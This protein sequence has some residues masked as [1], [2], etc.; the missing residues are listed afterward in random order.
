MRV[1]EAGALPSGRVVLS[2]PASLLRPPPTPWWPPATSRPSPVI[3]RHCFPSPAGSGP[4]RASPVPTTPLRP[5]HAPYAGG[6][7]GHP[8]QVPWCRPWPSPQEYRL[9]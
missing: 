9:G 2:L 6:F 1:D 4:P 5:F 8:L 3:G 7:L